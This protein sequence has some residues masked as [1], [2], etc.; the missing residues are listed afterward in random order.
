MLVTFM[1]TRWLLVYWIFF[2]LLFVQKGVWAASDGAISQPASPFEGNVCDHK[3]SSPFSLRSSFFDLVFSNAVQV[4]P[5]TVY[6][7]FR[8]VGRLIAVEARVDTNAG[9]FF[10]DTGAERLL[11]N[12]NHFSTNRGWREV[13]S[14]G[15]TGRVNRVFYNR[16]DT[17]YWDGLRL[18]KQQA[19]ILDLSHIERKKNIRLIGII[20]YEVLKEYEVFL[21]YEKK[22]IVLTRL[23]KK[24]FRLDPEA[25][26][27]QAY[28]SLDFKLAGYMIVLKGE[29]AGQK[30]RFALDTGAELNL[31]DRLVKRKVLDHFDIIKR[32]NMVGAG[33]NTVE[34][35]AGTLNELLCGRQKSSGMRTLLTNL[36]EMEGSLNVPLD[37]FLGYEFL[38][39]RRTLINY[40]RQKLFFFKQNRP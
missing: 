8:L 16:I 39:N 11:L 14:T 25:I 33:Q 31:L 40:K 34:V 37:G 17:L 12:S 6:I 13:A 28:D 30:L 35:L 10:L 21:D 24:G 4:N 26:W 32:V 29:V 22:Q 19:H 36:D 3:H 23:D 15:T 20:G 27:E 9:V 7:P 1:L 5:H 38:Y 2:F 18:P